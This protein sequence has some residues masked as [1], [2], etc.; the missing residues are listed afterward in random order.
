MNV[1]V[2]KYK[3]LRYNLFK[4][5]CQLCFAYKLALAFSFACLTGLLAQLRFYLPWTPVPITGQVF[6]VLLTGVLLGRWGGISQTMYI[7]FGAI[8]MPWFAGL[9]GGLA[10]LTGPTGGYILGFAAAAFFLG[11]LT[12]RYVKS[13]V[14]A[15]MLALMF[16][17]TFVL[18]YI[19]GLLCL[20]IWTGNS[21]SLW[22]LLTIGMLPYIAGDLLKIS[23][24]ATIAAA[25]TPK[26]AYNGEVDAKNGERDEGKTP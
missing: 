15:N 9:N 10:Y 24:A 11:Y 1:Y 3:K 6:A 21:V 17:A 18:I 16:F 13:R 20:Y 22:E 26:Q 7:G 14:F 23:A 19:P 4:K 12:D 25:V 5:R 2:N 8:G